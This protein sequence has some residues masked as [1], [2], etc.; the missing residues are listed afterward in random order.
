VD[1][2]VAWLAAHPTAILDILTTW[3][4]RDFDVYLQDDAGTTLQRR[5][6][7]RPGT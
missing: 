5:R 4:P 7:R 2:D 3:R 1:I 6:E